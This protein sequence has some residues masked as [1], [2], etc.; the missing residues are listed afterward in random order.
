MESLKKE[1]QNADKK[2]SLQTSR[3]NAT[4]SELNEEK[5]LGKALRNNQQQWQSKVTKLEN[6]YAEFKAAKEKEINDLKE[7]VRDLM[8]FIDAKQIIEKSE[9]KED[10]AGGTISVPDASKSKPK[11][12]KKKH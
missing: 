7:Q 1:K 10:I 8:F 4:L 11:K 2:L 6:K 9:D 12:V 3:L 5:Q